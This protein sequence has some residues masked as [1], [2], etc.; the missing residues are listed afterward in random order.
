MTDKTY[1]VRGMLRTV[2]FREITRFNPYGFLV[3][4]PTNLS[5][6]DIQG[7]DSSRTTVNP[8]LAPFITELFESRV[9]DFN[10]NMS[11]FISFV[12]LDMAHVDFCAE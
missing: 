9:V 12:T 4:L 5:H 1:G 7:V 6:S 10:A 3:K 8:T 2:C 11:R